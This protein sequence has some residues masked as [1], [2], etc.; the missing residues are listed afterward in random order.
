MKFAYIKVACHRQQHSVLCRMSAPSRVLKHALVI[1]VSTFHGWIQSSGTPFWIGSCVSLCSLKRCGPLPSEN[2]RFRK[3]WQIV[4]RRVLAFESLIEHSCPQL[5][6]NYED[7]HKSKRSTNSHH[8]W[9]I[10]SNTRYTCHC[11][12]N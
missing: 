5:Q 2:P 9:F 11:T 1:V 3:A 6:T 8:I 10:P 7:Q 12:P 4:T